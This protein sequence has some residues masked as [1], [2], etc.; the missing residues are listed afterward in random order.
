MILK[1]MLNVG[2]GKKVMMKIRRF[3][4]LSFPKPPAQ[5]SHTGLTVLPLNSPCKRKGTVA[6]L[7]SN[8]NVSIKKLFLKNGASW[9]NQLDQHQADVQSYNGKKA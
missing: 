1:I 3:L 8:T 2:K 6:S 5:Q 9:Q 4:P 7:P